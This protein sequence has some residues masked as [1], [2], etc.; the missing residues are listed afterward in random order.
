MYLPQVSCMQCS[1]SCE[2]SRSW[3]FIWS[4]ELWWSISR[5]LVL[6]LA[7]HFELIP[8]G[9]SREN[10]CAHIKKDLAGKSKSPHI[11]KVSDVSCAVEMFADFNRLTICTFIRLMNSR[12]VLRTL[13]IFTE[14]Q[15]S[16]WFC[17]QAKLPTFCSQRMR[18]LSSW[19]EG[20]LC[21]FRVHASVMLQMFSQTKRLISQ[22]Q[23]TEQSRRWMQQVAELLRFTSWLTKQ[24]PTLDPAP[25]RKIHA[26]P[27]PPRHRRPKWPSP[28]NVLSGIKAIMMWPCPTPCRGLR[29]RSLK[30]RER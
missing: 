18:S 19:S 5:F 21:V 25:T 9:A 14:G 16:L 15:L 7:S 13:P 12:I 4:D 30:W 24:L 1:V 22:K 26:K 17:R 6:F 27:R 8:S 29:T 11:C 2:T 20:G 3:D 10:L 23:R 28:R